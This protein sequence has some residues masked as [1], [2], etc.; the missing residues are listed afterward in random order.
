MLALPIEPLPLYPPFQVD[1]VDHT[2]FATDLLTSQ[3][4]GGQDVGLLEGYS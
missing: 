3:S 1:S 4:S 2:C